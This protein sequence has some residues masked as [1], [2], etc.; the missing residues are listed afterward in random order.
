MKLAAISGVGGVFSDEDIDRVRSLALEARKT[1]KP[2]NKGLNQ[3]NAW[4]AHEGTF[5]PFA[6]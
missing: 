1:W 2:P 3:G 6:L 5:A 4:Q